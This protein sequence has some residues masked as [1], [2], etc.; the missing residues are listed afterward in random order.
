MELL[1]IEP[2][3]ST[4]E[5]HFDPVKNE[6]RIKGQSYPENSFKFYEPVFAW[7]DE[8]LKQVTDEVTVA[9]HFHMPYIN[10]SSTKCLMM[11]LEKL[12]DA[13]QA[14]K[15]VSVIW[16][17]DADNETSLEC[18]EDFREDMKIPF[19]LRSMGETKK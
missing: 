5:I 9:L 8:Y 18:A 6:L 12:E 3:K 19:E 10:T 7:L 11:I 1:Y 4:P 2:A 16:Y 14:G 13:F 15:K 17:Y